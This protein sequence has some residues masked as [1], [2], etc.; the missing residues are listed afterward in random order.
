MRRMFQSQRRL[1]GAT[2]LLSPGDLQQSRNLIGD[3]VGD[4]VGDLCSGLDGDLV[5]GF[6]GNWVLRLRVAR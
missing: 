3:L 4:L 1:Q 5:G 2:R 6:R